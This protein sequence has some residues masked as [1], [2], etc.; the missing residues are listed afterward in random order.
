MKKIIWVIL[1]LFI[2]LTF[3]SIKIFKW[4]KDNIKTKNQVNEIYEIFYLNDY[5][6][7]TRENEIKNTFNN[8]FEYLKNI[9]ND[10]VGWIRI[11]GTNIDYPFV[12][13]NNNAFYLNHSFNGEN[14]EAG[15]IF[16]DY[17]NNSIYDKNTL[18]YAHSRLDKTMFGSLKNLLTDIWISDK[19][20]YN[21]YIY[22]I[23]ETTIW[24]IFSIYHI[25][26]TNDYLQIKFKNNSEFEQFSNMLI[27]RS[28]YDFNINILKSDRILT[29]S[30]CYKNDEKLVVHAKLIESIIR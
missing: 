29:L 17:R 10:T 23:N 22:T 12:Q 1:F 7:I 3:S 13:T 4:K 9:N 25:P 6:E 15:W 14:N 19:N 28:R 5:D 21:I 18:I 11:N 16:L 8:E 2:I 24:Q 27:K 26:N 20:N 30:T